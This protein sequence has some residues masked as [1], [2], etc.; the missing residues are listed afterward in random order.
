M[1]LEGDRY[2]LLCYVD[3]AGSSEVCT[4]ATPDSSP[5]LVLA[6]LIV[7]QPQQKDLVWDF[8]RIKKKFRPH[9]AKE[10][11]RLSE[12]IRTEIKGSDLR[13]DIRSSSRRRSR[14]AMGFIDDVLTLLES[15]NCTVIAEVVV[16]RDELGLR[17]EAVY[18]DSIANMAA[19]FNSQVAAANTAGIMVLDS[20]TKV[21]NVGSV[22]GITT[23]KFSAGG[24]KLANLAE[25]PVFG[26]S[27]SH[28]L[29]QVADVL[30]SAV[31]F[32]MACAAYCS[33]MTWN[34]HAN[35]KYCTV[36]GRC[37][38]RVQKLEYRYVD[39]QGVWRG[40]LRVKDW[41]GHQGT[42]HLFRPT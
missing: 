36:W 6:G 27:D 13:A 34:T 33:S 25:A 39:A 18:P 41:R 4:R 20:R 5:L 7:A 32:P 2:V 11:T 10:A 12:L 28:V 21:K 22:H 31:L 29:L 1:C 35:T 17:D 8:L 14:A 30:A 16:K 15:R 19:A 9:L 23:R 40:G 38:E 24:D 3:E 37:A 26:H 42:A